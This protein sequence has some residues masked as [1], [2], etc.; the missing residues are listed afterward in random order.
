MIIYTDGSCSKNGSAEAPGGF[1]VVILDDAENLVSTHSESTARTTNNRMELS[2]ILW[3]MAKY[4][5]ENPI[6]Y[7]DSAYAIN[8]LTTW[9]FSWRRKGW[10]KADKK[11]PENLDLIKA[12]H[13]LY[14]LGYRITLRKCTGHSGEKWNE[15]ADKLARRATNGEKT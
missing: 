3:V 4:G 14:D 9:S 15:L 5:K 13:K 12:Y 10:V 2:A 1:G 8:T 11:I 7:S 6:I